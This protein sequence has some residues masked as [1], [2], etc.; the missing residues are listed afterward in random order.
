[1]QFPSAA[2]TA[3]CTHD[4]DICVPC[5]RSYVSVGITG[6]LDL[7]CPTAD[8]NNHMDVSEVQAGL[9][10]SHRK[11]FERF[12]DLKVRSML[13][14]EQTWVWC[15]APGCGSGQMHI[16]GGDF[17]IVTCQQCSA[18]TCFPHGTVWHEGRTCAEFDE[19]LKKTERGRVWIE[20]KQSETW[21]RGNTK[22][23]PGKGCSR[24]IQ[25]NDGCDHMT[26]R[27]P[28]GCGHEFCWECLAPYAP[29]RE[30]GNRLHQPDCKYYS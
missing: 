29:I 16:G 20:A 24:P 21:I 8:C 13:Q 22:I 12:C 27:R 9:G 28:A 25:K 6:T 1:M 19:D 17:P 30:R 2:P 23:C 11:E 26:C 18:R 10:E 7:R 5:L 14:N 15:Q 3:R 4:I